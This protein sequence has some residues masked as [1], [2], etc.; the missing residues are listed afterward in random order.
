VPAALIVFG[1][2]SLESGNTVPTI[3]VLKI[4]GDASYSIYMT[5]WFAWLAVSIVVA[6]LGGSLSLAIYF[7]TIFVAII[8]GVATYVCVEQP[9]GRFL[10]RILATPASAAG[11]HTP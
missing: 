5:H 2:V 9:M 3:R 4:L 6:K 8:L 10:S 11:M 1:A 7:A